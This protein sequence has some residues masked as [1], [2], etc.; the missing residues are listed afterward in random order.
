MT[1]STSGGPGPDPAGA[2]GLEGPDTPDAPAEPATAPVVPPVAGTAPAM[3]PAA[4]P[5]PAAKKPADSGGGPLTPPPIPRGPGVR[6]PFA[7]PPR[8]GNRRRMW[9]GI[10]IGAAV[11]VICFGGGGVGIGALLVTTTNHRIDAAR[12]VVTDFMTDW[13]K[14]DF[15]AAYQLVCAEQ[16]RT[17]SPTELA[18]DLGPDPVDAFEVRDPTL[19]TEAVEVPVRIQY[20]SGDIETQTFAV[21][22]D[23]D[24]SSKVCG[25]L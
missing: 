22:V 3:P 15:S 2:P 13:Q 24:Q 5:V 10:G 19:G 7:A 16:R 17:G 21:T 11:A 9:T 4:G 8:E 18:A 25:T 1:T 14:Q 12:T 20:D 6:P 23:D